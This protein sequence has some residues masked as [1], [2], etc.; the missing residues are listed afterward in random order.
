MDTKALA[1]TD[2]EVLKNH[3]CKY[4]IFD[5]EELPNGGQIAIS[6]DGALAFIIFVY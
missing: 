2:T 1:L 6:E 3:I 5:A 4:A